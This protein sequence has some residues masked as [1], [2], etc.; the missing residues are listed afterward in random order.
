MVNINYD[1]DYKFDGF[2]VICY[3]FSTWNISFRNK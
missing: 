3:S 2:Y 1:N